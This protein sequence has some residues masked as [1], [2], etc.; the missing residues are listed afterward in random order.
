[1]INL[2]FTMNG[3][4]LNTEQAS[5]FAQLAQWVVL[6]ER[7]GRLLV[8]G[9]GNPESVAGVMAQLQQLG[10]A[11]AVVGGWLADG[12]PAPEYPLN[13]PEWCAA[14]PNVIDATNPEAPLFVR[15]TAFNEIHQWGGW[16]PKQ[17]PAN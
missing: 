5:A 12:T 6:N 4:R 3:P 17:I 1:M 11:P 9:I 16:E 8:D 2:I 14:A 13:A 7:N 15:P 10:R